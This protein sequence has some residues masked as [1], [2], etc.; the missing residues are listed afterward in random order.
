MGA[1]YGLRVVCGDQKGRR[2][3]LTILMMITVVA[4]VVVVVVIPIRMM[5]VVFSMA[6]RLPEGARVLR[7]P[8]ALPAAVRPRGGHPAAAGAGGA[9]P[10]GGDQALTVPGPSVPVRRHTAW[11][12]YHDDVVDGDDDDD[13]GPSVP[14]RK[15]T[16]WEGYHDDVDDVDDDDG[17]GG[18]GYHVVMIMDLCRRSGMLLMMMM[19]M[20][21]DYRTGE[22]KPS[23]YLD[24][25]C[26]YVNTLRGKVIMTMLMMMMMSMMVVVVVV[27][28]VQV[29]H[30]G[31]QAL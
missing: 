3:P 28:V 18:G 24:R 30:R 7:V 5:I 1:E 26:Q 21:M 12:G 14:V 9:L 20:M 8:G 2:M 22:T 17:G 11:E 19:M 29:P 10:H 6:G 15:H 25:L 31:D 27:V 13:D 16:A 4:A 23:K